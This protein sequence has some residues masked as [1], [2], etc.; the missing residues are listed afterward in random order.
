[1]NTFSKLYEFIGK[2]EG[3]DNMDKLF[4]EEGILRKV[5]AIEY[6]ENGKSLNIQI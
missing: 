4:E 3:I 5:I 1:M 6:E 2:L